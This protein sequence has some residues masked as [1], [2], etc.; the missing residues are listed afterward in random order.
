MQAPTPDQQPER[1]A[2]LHR[3]DILDTSAEP[4]LDEITRI[5]ARACG[6]PVALITLVDEHRQ[7]FKSAVGFERRETP[8]DVSFCA[9]AIL[10]PGVFVVP[11]ALQDERFASNLLVT[12]PPNFRF[13]AGAPLRTSDG[14]QLGTLCVFDYTPRAWTEEQS[15]LLGLLARQVMLLFEQHRSLAWMGKMSDER[16]AAEAALRLERGFLR[17]VIDT[18]PSLVFVKDWNGRFVLANEALARCYGTTVDAVVGKTDAD[19]NGDSEEVRHFV[20]DDREV[21]STRRMKLIAEEPVTSAD[22]EVHWF[23]TVKVPLVNDDGS[24]DSLLG[25]ATDITAQ[26]RAAAALLESEKLHR[27]MGEVS[28]GFVWTVNAEGRFEYVNRTWEEFTGSTCE[29]LNA[30]GW[31]RF[32]HPDELAEVQT[33]WLEAAQ[34][35]LPFEMEL[36]YRRRDGQYRWMLSR[37]VPVLNDLGGVARW[38]GSSVDIHDLKQLDEAR[39]A[40]DERLRQAQRLE[41]VGRLAGGVAHDLNNMLVAILGYSDFLGRSLSAGDARLEDVAE[42]TKAASRSAA[43]TRQLLAFARR[44]RV[45]PNQF[46]LNALVR[47]NERMLRLAMGERITLELDLDQ[48]VLLVHA[49]ANRIEQVLLNLCLNARDAMPNE[50]RLC[51]RTRSTHLDA[52]YGERHPG[53]EIQPGPYVQLAVS[54]SGHGMDGPTLSHVFEPFFTTKAVGQ[55]TGLGLSSAYGTVKQA[56]GFIWAYSEPGSG[57]VF[58]VYLPETSSVVDQAPGPATSEPRRGS[59]VI[60]VVDDAEEVRSATC[61]GLEQYGYTCLKAASGAEALR[62]LR[63][64]QL[65][66]DLIVTDVVMPELNGL[67]LAREV[68]RLRPGMPLLFVSGYSEHDLVHRGLLERGSPFLEKPFTSEAAATRV[69]ELLLKV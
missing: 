1:L 15:D 18:Q 25:V 12:D 4:Q 37:V 10:Q 17:K 31:Q 47:A 53:T 41:A 13:Y 57:S 8:L 65:M 58:K 21:M 9:H 51:V 32:N 43:L 35:A 26:R 64:D 60:L 22:G 7:W 40:S 48:R 55:G 29:D 62:R 49:D 39:R 63:E 36:R 54:D 44:E 34:R 67:E 19:L 61:R 14:F 50:G 66:V 30:N 20:R 59:G 11:D 45:D 3:Y 24:C 56:G 46:D 38:V 28:P 6:A 23:S 42:I 27:I 52:R 68:E 33:R 5:V 2:A 69:G 16:Q